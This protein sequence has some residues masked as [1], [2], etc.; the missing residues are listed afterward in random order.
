VSHRPRPLFIV[1]G[2]VPGGPGRLAT[3]G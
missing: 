2:S 3:E 1:T